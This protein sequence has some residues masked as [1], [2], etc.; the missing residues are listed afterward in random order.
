MPPLD[1]VNTTVD[2]AMPTA[3]SWSSSS[4]NA[5]A[6]PSAPVAVLPPIGIEYG[7]KALPGEHGGHRFAGDLE[8]TPVVSGRTGVVE[9]GAEQ[10]RQQLV[11]RRRAGSGPVAGEH[12]VYLEPEHRAGGRRHPTMVGL[13]CP[14]GDE[15][16]R[17]GRDGCTAQEFE[18]AC[19]VP[20][21]AETGQ[22][23]TLHPEAGTAGSSRHSP[24]EQRAGLERGRQGGQRCPVEMCEHFRHARQPC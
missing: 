17:P 20:A 2:G 19:L 24:G 15:C 23:I 8:L 22:V 4:T 5:F 9:L 18:F 7:T 10:L 11:A 6:Y 21:A 12:E 16:P 1:D 13:C 14:D 3:S